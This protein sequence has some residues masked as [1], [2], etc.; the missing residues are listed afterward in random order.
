MK[1]GESFQV[2][3]AWWKAG[4][5]GVLTDTGLSGALRAF[6][7]ADQK[8]Q[9]AH[10]AIN[11]VNVMK[12]LD[13]VDAARVATIQKCGSNLVLK[14]T[15]NALAKDGAIKQ[16]KTVLAEVM[17]TEIAARVLKIEG[18]LAKETADATAYVAQI[19][20][21]KGKI[22]AARKAKDGASLNKLGKE[23][24]RISMNLKVFESGSSASDLQAMGVQFGPAMNTG[25]FKELSDRL[26][27][28]KAGADANM[29]KVK[30]MKAIIDENDD[31]ITED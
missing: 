10:N 15:K 28:V 4:K 19:D 25:H 26:K 2:T 21:L 18:R 29:A 13:A 16:R 27:T 3:E 11:F 1:S 23:L 6:D 31:L 9:S 8:F 12:A 24:T 14:D 17:R 30:A 20:S 7:A 5:P 22:A